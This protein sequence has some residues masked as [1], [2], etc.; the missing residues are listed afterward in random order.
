MPTKL[1]KKK[2]SFDFWANI[3][4]DGLKMYFADPIFTN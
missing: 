3:K 1:K 2:S 4:N